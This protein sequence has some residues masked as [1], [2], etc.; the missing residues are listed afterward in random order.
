MRQQRYDQYDFQERKP[1]TVMQG[2]GIG[3]EALRC[4]DGWN[5]TTKVN[6]QKQH[7]QQAAER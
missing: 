6:D 2:D 5:Q 7:E 3:L 1:G 4:C